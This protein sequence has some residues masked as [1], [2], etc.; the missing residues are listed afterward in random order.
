MR[1]RSPGTNAAEPVNDNSG[2]E[3][4]KSRITDID[5]LITRK[6]AIFANET[7]PF[8]PLMK[9][10]EISFHGIPWILFLVIGIFITHDIQTHS[11][12][13][14][15]LFGEKREIIKYYDML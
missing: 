13:I 5:H 2:T 10:I 11:K 3:A 15:L 1:N 12:L 7:S 4:Q 14:N 9:L 6:I 8:R